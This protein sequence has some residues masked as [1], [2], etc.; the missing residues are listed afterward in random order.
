MRDADSEAQELALRRV[1]RFALARG[2]LSQEGLRECLL[3]QQRLLDSGQPADLL[4]ILRARA[5][6][7]THLA[8]LGA[9]YRAALG[10]GASEGGEL[11]PARSLSPRVLEESHEA[12]RLP[13]SSDPGPVRDFLRESES[14]TLRDPHAPQRRAEAAPQLE[15]IG[16][17]RVLRELGRGA[18]G[19]VYHAHSSLLDRPVALKV[20]RDSDLASEEE[21]ERFLVEARAAARLRHPNIVGIHH[22]G[23]EAGRHYLVLD[24]VE[25]ESLSARLARE[26]ALAEQEAARLAQQLC[27]ALDYAHR[28]QILHRDIKPDNVL[29]DREGVPR[30]TDFGLAKDVRAGR[31]LTATGDVVGT[32]A[33]MPPEQALGQVERIDRRADVYALGATLFEMLTGQRPFTGAT[34]LAVMQAAV[35]EE[36]PALRELRPELSLDVETLCL[37]C[38]EKDPAER[39]LSAAALGEDLRRL[40]AGEPISARPLSPLGRLGRWA[41]RRPAAAL[42]LFL[43]ANGLVLGGGV[44]LAWSA[45]VEQERRE[46]A[47][48]ERQRVREEV[49]AIL[50]ALRDDPART[51][52]DLLAAYHALLRRDEP[53]AVEAMIARLDQTSRALREAAR[54]YLE[55]ALPRDAAEGRGLEGLGEA[56]ADLLSLEPGQRLPERQ[57]GVLRRAVARLEARAHVGDAP[58]SPPSLEAALALRQATRRDELAPAKVLCSVFARLELEGSL[59]ADVVESLGRY[60]A[61]ERDPERAVPAGQA[62]A[63]L[64]GPRAQALLE[65]SKEAFG[66]AGG[67]YWRQ[68]RQR[69]NAIEAGAVQAGGSGPLARARA[70]LREGKLQAAE[71]SASEA[72]RVGED[73]VRAYCLRAQVLRRRRDYAGA[74]R[75]SLHALELESGSSEASEQLI[76]LQLELG[77]LDEARR[78]L[79]RA[80][81]LSPQAAVLYV[82]RAELGR[83]QGRWEEALGDAGQAIELDP[84]D[85]RGWIARGQVQ[86]ARE[87]QR[88][89]LRDFQ[90]AQ[91]VKPSSCAAL[92]ALAAARWALGER[93]AALRD[94]SRALELARGAPAEERAA[95]LR[96]ARFRHEEG[97]QGEALEDV[98]QALAL[99][100]DRAEALALRGAILGQR[101]DFARAVEDLTQA[102]EA[103]AGAWDFAPALVN[104]GLCYLRQHQGAPALADFEE[105]IRRDPGFAQAWAQRA[106]ARMLQGD[107]AGAMTDVERALELAPRDAR[108]WHQ[109]GFLE[110]E[111]CGPEPRRSAGAEAHLRAAREAFDRGLLLAPKDLNLR[112]GRARARAMGGDLPG[113]LADCDAAVRLAPR[114]PIPYVERGAWRIAQPD[115]AGARADFQRALELAPPGSAEAAFA[116]QQLERLR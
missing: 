74:R 72:I 90:Q 34:A 18:F 21:V 55:R 37:K 3:I 65:W 68:V 99:P 63:R 109:K 105:A 59:R 85:E 25:G 41:R 26:G 5:L 91:E 17:Y 86:Q 60:L 115:A 78:A 71:R 62:L 103:S 93:E 42:G 64:G 102:I 80:I 75:D 52:E 94:V 110:L 112:L 36:P 51:Q 16:D 6:A 10:S 12:L 43:L 50:N 92:R 104:R 7:P 66:G 2:Y 19:I 101:G 29:L 32:P 14:A 35:E 31:G 4:G 53:E 84:A 9:V 1:V 24:Y 88:G 58:S 89:A 108:V 23:C 45:A 38:L 98:A 13:P 39:Y 67:S 47:A 96:R 111:L 44:S 83:R 97:K 61:A 8:E 70:E 106:A 54:A 79:A 46:Q 77:E 27:H 107:R 30:L 56:I 40:L 76:R 82:L 116:R 11:P 73:R 113:A 69:L 28:Q 100:G 57:L 114:S 49:D 95:L 48:R 20:L 81:E 15:R 22:V 87:D 33:Y